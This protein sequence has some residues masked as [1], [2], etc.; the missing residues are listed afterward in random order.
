M[1]GRDLSGA[2]K[3]KAKNQKQRLST[4]L[5]KLKQVTLFFDTIKSEKK[6]FCTVTVV[7]RPL[8][9]HL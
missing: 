7:P 1:S 9:L 5:E 2:A 4:E 3:R 6:D 8:M